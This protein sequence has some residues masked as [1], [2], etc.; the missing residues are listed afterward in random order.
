[1]NSK[2]MEQYSGDMI[3]SGSEDTESLGPER[4]RNR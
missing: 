2:A 1:M 4:K 3:W